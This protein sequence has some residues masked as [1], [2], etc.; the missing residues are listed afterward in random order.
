MRYLV[1][2]LA[3]V[4]PIAAA[5]QDPLPAPVLPPALSELRPRAEQLQGNAESF[6]AGL[7]EAQALLSAY[8]ARIAELE[9]AVI[10][11]LDALEARACGGQSPCP[12]P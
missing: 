5:A 9:G 12:P 11:R 2:A 7:S 6:L 4:L 3:L 8:A 1:I 10:I